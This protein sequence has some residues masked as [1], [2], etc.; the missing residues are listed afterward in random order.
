MAIPLRR[1]E[2]NRS[3]ETCKADQKWPANAE[4]HRVPNRAILEACFHHASR[5]AAD[6][7]AP[8]RAALI[9]TDSS[10]KILLDEHGN[11]KGG[12]RVPETSVPVETIIPGD[13]G[14]RVNCAGIGYSIPFSRKKLVELYGTR[15]KYLA[16]Y[17]AAADKL[18][19]DG[20]IL[21][22]GASQLKSSRR[23]LAPVF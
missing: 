16:L 15:E 7:V 12:L 3:F 20:Y 1:G 17:D 8:P 14:G 11:A 18:V 10:G 4:A 2:G 6:G 5:W 9:E 23:W 22:E 13:R 21:P 19:N